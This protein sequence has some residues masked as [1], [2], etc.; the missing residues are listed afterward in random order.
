MLFAVLSPQIQTALSIHGFDYSHPILLKPA[1]CTCSKIGLTIFGFAIHIRIFQKPNLREQQRKPVVKTA[2]TKI[3]NY[4]KTADSEGR[5][6]FYATFNL[7][8]LHFQNS[9]L[10]L[11]NLL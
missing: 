6:Y 10:G 4:T 3:A 8:T 1:S 5:L 9:F 7:G 11:V 2:N